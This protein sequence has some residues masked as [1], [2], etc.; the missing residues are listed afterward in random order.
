MA[1]CGGAAAP[2]SYLGLSA[3]PGTE[4]PAAV[5]A[6]GAGAAGGG[7]AAASGGVPTTNQL[8]NP[9]AFCQ[10]VQELLTLL[11][12]LVQLGGSSATVASTKALIAH[13]QADA[14]S[15]ILPQVRLVVQTDQRI[16]ADLIAKPPNLA[17]LAQAFQD[18][19]YQAAVQQI[20]A[21]AFDR[22]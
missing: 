15:D 21:Y 18:P 1:A 3:P 17:D 7:A 9:P 2:G 22:C 12:R 19:S 11:P 8:G 20:G 6:A 5:A 10:D 14:P 16:V 13:I 4:L